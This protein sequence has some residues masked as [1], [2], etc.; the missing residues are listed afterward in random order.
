[1]KLEKAKICLDD[2]TVFEGRFCPTCGKE[3]GWRLDTW[4][5]PLHLKRKE[6]E[7][8]EAERKTNEF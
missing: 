5:K 4:V 1:M 7:S 8:N 2:D 6:R 3:D